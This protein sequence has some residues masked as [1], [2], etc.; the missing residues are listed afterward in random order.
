VEAILDDL[1]AAAKEHPPIPAEAVSDA[2]RME[3]PRLRV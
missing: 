2:V 1:R 3:Y